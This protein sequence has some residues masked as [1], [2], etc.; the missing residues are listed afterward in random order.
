M[1]FSPQ[2]N[3]SN[4]SQ[5][6]Y[7]PGYSIDFENFTEHPKLVHPHYIVYREPNSKIYLLSITIYGKIQEN[8]ICGTFGAMTLQRELDYKVGEFFNFLILKI[9]RS[10]SVIKGILYWSPVL[11]FT[12][13]CPFVG[14]WVM[15]ISL[16]WNFAQR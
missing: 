13:V 4:T 1:N 10:K 2:Y 5:F 16:L 9:H 3:F 7:P 6:W 15:R 11:Q 8:V 12:L 14:G